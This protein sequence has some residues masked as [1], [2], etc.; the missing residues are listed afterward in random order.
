MIEIIV[1]LLIVVLYVLSPYVYPV[2]SD[3]PMFLTKAQTR[4]FILNDSDNYISNFDPINMFSRGYR[5]SAPPS[6]YIADSAKSA[7]SFT[8]SE[9]QTLTELTR[10]ADEIIR[11]PNA[12]PTRVIGK[13]YAKLLASIPWKFAKTKGNHYENG[14]SHTRKDIIFVSSGELNELGELDGS[15]LIH[16]KMHIFTR[17]YKKETENILYQYGFT[18]IRNFRGDSAKVINMHR[19]NPDTNINTYFNSSMGKLFTSDFYN[20]KPYYTN[21][22]S[23]SLHE[24]H[25]YEWLA[26]QITL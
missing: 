22:I 20:P 5:K 7:M 23:S 26:Y 18:N 16:E 14:L 4:Q 15:T 24:E 13:K 25:P 11:D 21:H 8:S 10:Q 2:M 9:K 12:Q 1:I 6:K 17:Y 19:Y 3:T